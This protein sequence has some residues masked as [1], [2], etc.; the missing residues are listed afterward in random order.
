MTHK[1]A[2]MIIVI[3]LVMMAP[4]AIEA[5]QTLGLTISQPLL[6]RADQVIR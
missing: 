1:Q 3:I 6:Q 2:G 5:Q 4:L